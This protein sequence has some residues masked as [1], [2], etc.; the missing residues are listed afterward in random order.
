V[1]RESTFCEAS[2]A[3]VQRYFVV[4][5]ASVEV[6]QF[7]QNMQAYTDEEMAAIF[8]E[9]GF[10]SLQCLPSLEGVPSEGQEDLK[11]WKAK[12]PA[13]SSSDLHRQA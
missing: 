13:E 4:D 8:E 3:A 12:R 1:L 2:S 9:A 5:T 7:N 10:A 11:V 6:T